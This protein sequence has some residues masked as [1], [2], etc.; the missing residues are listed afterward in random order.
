MRAREF[1]IEGIDGNADI[2]KHDR[3]STRGLNIYADGEK[4]NTD[5]T[6][7]RIMMAT[8]CTDGTFVPDMDMKSWVG[9]HKTAHP[10]TQE[11]QNMLKMAYK[12]AGARWDDLNHGDMRSQELPGGN[13]KSPIKG[14]RGY[15]R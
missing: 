8:A 9:K 13:P 4:W 7:N 2:S 15:A 1:I 5:Y 14:F 10:Y 6:L 11:E 3:Y 12:A